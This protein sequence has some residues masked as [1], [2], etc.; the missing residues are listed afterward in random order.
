MEADDAGTTVQPT[1]NPVSRRETPTALKDGPFANLEHG[2]VGVSDPSAPRPPHSGARV[3][4]HSL[5]RGL[6]CLPTCRCQ[7]SAPARLLGRRWTGWVPAACR[8][9]PALGAQ[10]RWLWAVATAMRPAPLQLLLRA[11]WGRCGQCPVSQQGQSEH[12]AGT[13][14]A[15]PS[16]VAEEGRGHSQRASDKLLLRARVPWD[17]AGENESEAQAWGCS[18]PSASGR[19]LSEQGPWTAAG[20][21]ASWRRQRRASPDRGSP[22]VGG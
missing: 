20:L 18:P 6:G 9:G 3:H 1:A 7:G 13:R 8:A 15:G 14:P 11:A 5:G 19:L 12:R 21:G 16:R 4:R 17:T 22:Q 10:Q 2:H